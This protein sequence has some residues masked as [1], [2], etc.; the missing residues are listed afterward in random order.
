M[1]NDREAVKNVVAYEDSNGLVEGTNSSLR[2]IKR[3]MYGK[4]NREL[5]EA[6]LRYMRQEKT[7]NCGRPILSRIFIG[8]GGNAN[9]GSW[10]YNKPKIYY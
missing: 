4:C 7:D 3:T 10:M 8:V 5:L 2:M 1:E 9:T 6:K